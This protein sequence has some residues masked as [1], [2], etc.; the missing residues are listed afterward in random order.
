MGELQCGG[1]AWRCHIREL[2]R[3]WFF[4]LGH[5]VCS[6]FVGAEENV[7]TRNCPCSFEV[8]ARKEWKVICWRTNVWV[9]VEACKDKFGMFESHGF[10]QEQR[11]WTW[12]SW[13]LEGISYI[14]RGLD[15][16]I[17]VKGKF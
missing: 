17:L 2:D 14:F 9:T 13:K 5:C 6:P 16:F 8:P 3:T 1:F 10:V 11:A 15:F 7:G 12:C 4:F